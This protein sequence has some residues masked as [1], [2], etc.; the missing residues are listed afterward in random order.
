MKRVMGL[1]VVAGLSALAG[2]QQ[3]AE[4]LLST[5]PRLFVRPAA[6]EGGP[7]LAQLRARA[8]QSP[9]KERMHL[10]RDTRADL[11]LKWLM[12]GGDDAGSAALKALKSIPADV[13]ASYEGVDLV[14]AALA[15][16]WLF[17]WKGFTDADKRLVE[18][19]MLSLAGHV[20]ASLFNEGAHIFHTRM[21][22]WCAGLGMTGL[23]LHD[24]RPEALA[25]WTAGRDYYRNV[26]IP[27]RR[28]QG[29]AMHNGLSYGPNY[30]MFPLLQFLLAARS[31]ANVDWFHTADPA[32]S[33]W[34]RDMSDYL[35][36][37]VQPDLNFISVGDNADLSAAKQ[38]RFMLDIFAAQYGSGQDAELA[39]RISD[40][41]KTSGYHAE[42]IYLFLTQHDPKVAAAPL[43]RLPRFRVFSPTGLGHVFYRSDWSDDGMCVSFRC[44]DYF[45]DHGHFDQGNF[46][47]FRDT[48][49]AIQAGCYI[50][51]D[52]AHRH[53]YY[54]QAVASNTVI[55]N[56]PADPADEGT[57]RN[58]HYQEASSV[59]EYEAHRKLVET[60][61]LLA[62]DDP[63]W[64]SGDGVHSVVADV[65]PAW[66]AAK[67]KR[68][69]RTMAFTGEHVVVVDQAQTMRPAVRARWL[70]HA[71]TQ[72]E[73][74]GGV[75]RIGRPRASLIV[76]P[77]LPRTR[78]VTLIGG[79]GH[80]C[81]VN[82]VNYTYMAV[83]KNNKRK[84][85][86]SVV[87]AWGLWR[88]E[89]EGEG[90]VGEDGVTH[91][92]YV[93]VLTAAGP[94]AAAP[95]AD[96]GFT[97]SGWLTVTVDGRKITFNK[98]QEPK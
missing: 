95:K 81:D 97:D 51:F 86:K 98:V 65:T 7:S 61:N 74:V 73:E 89:L 10:L 26:L 32:D 45:G 84:P 68:Y 13:T 30:M 80:E 79:P 8:K 49:L 5:H 18:D 58:I 12:L 36:Y 16:D 35:I 78:R 6:W 66:D 15:Y 22:A 83:E 93:T 3:K 28:M 1:L 54:K 76:Q 37:A 82:G 85:P 72:P 50:G 48:P 21:Y 20:K 96:V 94:D 71:T 34:L 55:F 39:S 9:F 24:R 88:M 2:C 67:V 91:R 90:V 33:D 60:G 57:Q 44:G 11:A 92:L 87:P 70:L 41:L 52:V 62:V 77:L 63:A 4:T 40:R 43:D 42:W 64:V 17:N 31:A 14:D 56:D 23:A 47:I 27:A 19:R 25:L 69:V 38:I 59:A 29:G 46:T 53:H 75:W